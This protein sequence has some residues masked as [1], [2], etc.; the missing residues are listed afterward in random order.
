MEI[1]LRADLLPVLTGLIT[2]V[3]I[4]LFSK[5]RIRDFLVRNRDFFKNDPESNAKKVYIRILGLIA[6]DVVGLLCFLEVIDVFL[7]VSVCALIFIGYFYL[8][9]KVG[10]DIVELWGEV[11]KEFNGSMVKTFMTVFGGRE[12][13]FEYRGHLIKM[14]E[15]APYKVQVLGW[16]G[17]RYGRQGGGKMNFYVT[18]SCYRDLKAD[19]FPWDYSHTMDYKEISDRFDLS[20]DVAIAILRMGEGGFY[21]RKGFFVYRVILPWI[22]SKDYLKN[23]AEGLL[24]VAEALDRC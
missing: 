13:S 4:L 19:I 15:Y 23:K 16:R 18:H 7:G 12:Y 9:S 24:K 8:S 21:L 6:I 17:F 11:A 3:V 14:S 20:P 10:K 1:T 5:P 2:L 22:I